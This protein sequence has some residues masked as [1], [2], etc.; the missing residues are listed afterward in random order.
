MIFLVKGRNN[1]LTIIHIHLINKYLPKYYHLL[2]DI[3]DNDICSFQQINFPFGTFLTQD[4]INSGLYRASLSHHLYLHINQA[5]LVKHF[6]YFTLFTLG[7]LGN[8]P[9]RSEL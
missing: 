2:E 1:I 4:R 7:S 3:S 9:D 5:V 8:Q 6:L